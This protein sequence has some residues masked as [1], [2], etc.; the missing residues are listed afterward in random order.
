VLAAIAFHS[1]FGGQ[2][3]LGFQNPNEFHEVA[4]ERVRA[5]KDSSQPLPMALLLM[6]ALAVH[7]PLLLMQLPLRSYDTNFH[8]FFASHYL[9]HW[10]D[11]WNPK[12]FGGFSQA[13]YPPLPHQWIAVLSHVMGLNLAYMAVQLAG[14][15]LLCVGS[16][17]FALLWV[18]PRAASFAAL[19]SVLLG[20]ES[21][22]VYN[23]GQIGTTC[24]A[25]LYL[26]ALPYLY[27]WLR[28]GGFRPFL[29]ATVLFA[30]AACVHHLTL[31]FG[32]MLFAL[33]VFALAIMDRKNEEGKETSVSAVILRGVA[34]TVIVG[35][36]VGAALLPFWI[37]LIRY[38]VTQ[39]PIPHASRASFILSPF[40]GINYFL[41]PYGALILALPFIV[42]R[43]A[44]TTR[45]RPLMLGFW[46]CFLFGL[47]GTT[48]VGVWLLGRAFQVLTMERFSYWATLLA[49]PILG[50][51]VS[52]MVERFRLRA[53]VPLTI[54]ALVS[55]GS[56]IGWIVLRPTDTMEFST[57]PMADWLNRGGHD[58]Y[59]YIALGIGN[60]LSELAMETNASSVDGEWYSDRRLPE[61]MQYGGGSLNNS[62]YFGQNGMNALEAILHHAYRYGLK[63]VFVRDPYFDPLLEFAGWRQVDEVD[64][65]AITIW[66]KDGIPPATPLNQSLMPP[67]WEGILW[68]TLP[69]GTSIAALLLLFIPDRRLRRSA[70]DE[71]SPSQTDT[72]T[73]LFGRIA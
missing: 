50:A 41:V 60:K 72:E 12:W 53:A 2:R 65:G 46:L 66:A 32:S 68:G 49:L 59:R 5:F 22:L 6:A 36:I 23:A 29:K 51:L 42:I 3:R 1:S 15:L 58:K 21:F 62:R 37:G 28:L 18:S 9:H 27:E 25:P 14:I 4:L 8:I 30:A 24:A 11:P 20:S 38:P 63:W 43:G 13:T 69:F 34:I 40:W 52:D 33:P 10:F 35:V 54:L 48:P 61:L 47:G 55:F 45:L 44:M 7:L 17:R 31:L 19:A 70:V 39:T 26:L 71:E 16:Y 67:R 73:V 56:A 64:N 57:Q